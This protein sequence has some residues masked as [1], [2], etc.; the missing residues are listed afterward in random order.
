MPTISA[1]VSDEFNSAIASAAKVSSEK[2][3][4][5]WLA[6]SAKQRLIRDGMMPGDP[7]T[8]VM[9]AAA[10]LGYPQALE[11]LRAAGRSASP[12]AMTASQEAA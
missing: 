4:G 8:E 9:S 7:A 12:E 1:H 10:A 6:E 5:P 11:V 3:V 2:K